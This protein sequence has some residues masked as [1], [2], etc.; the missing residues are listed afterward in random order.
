MGD[1]WGLTCW[2]GRA[3]GCRQCQ[4]A[5]EE[6]HKS[7]VAVALL[8]SLCKLY[9][10]EPKVLLRL[11]HHFHLG[12]ALVHAGFSG[13]PRAACVHVRL[14]RTPSCLRYM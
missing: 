10:G 11:A 3:H 5:A 2:R 7:K 9:L 8:D 13:L 12:T 6:G 4:L 1:G 14:P